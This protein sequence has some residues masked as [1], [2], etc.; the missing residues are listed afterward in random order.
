M[1]VYILHFLHS[2]DESDLLLFNAYL[3]VAS[4]IVAIFIPCLIYSRSRVRV[5]S[6]KIDLPKAAKKN[7]HGHIK[8]SDLVDMK[9]AEKKL[10]PLPFHDL[11]HIM[12]LAADGHHE[13]LQNHVRDLELDPFNVKWYEKELYTPLDMA[14]SRGHMNVVHYLTDNFPSWTHYGNEAIKE[15]AKNGQIEIVEYLARKLHSIRY[16]HRQFDQREILSYMVHGGNT[17]AVVRFLDN[18][19]HLVNTKDRVGDYPIS[20][21]AAN[22]DSQMAFH[23]LHGGFTQLLSINSFDGDGRQ[24]IHLAAINGHQ[25]VIEMLINAGAEYD[26]PTF[27]ADNEGDKNRRFGNTPLHFA[28]GSG[29]F[30]CCKLLIDR[31]ADILKRNN[32]GDTPLHVAIFERSLGV[33]S[34]FRQQRFFSGAIMSI[35]NNSGKDPHNLARNLLNE[36]PDDLF[37]HLILQML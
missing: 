26:N 16:S 15:A 9:R 7:G 8:E 20:I 27:I 4:T 14:A 5:M 6:K 12:Q 1:G 34:Y 32:D 25:I 29:H 18:Q 31:G 21:A 13:S 22:G 19:R 36:T 23:L 3:V 37:L 35:K 10:P 30:N 2:Q 11:S 28:A 24:P 17:K 33:V